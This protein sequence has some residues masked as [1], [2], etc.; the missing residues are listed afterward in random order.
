METTFITELNHEQVNVS[1]DNIPDHVVYYNARIEWGLHLIESTREL[2][3][4]PF[5]DR[6]IIWSGEDARG[7][8][9][10]L[11]IRNMFL[12]VINNENGSMLPFKLLFERDTNIK[13]LTTIV[14]K[15]IDIN[16][17]SKEVEVLFN[18]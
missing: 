17:N 6:L 9:K 7:S 10:M 14:P 1:G 11:I 12:D 4:R 18:A 3:I 8:D 2:D 16:L 5:V 13:D 15:H